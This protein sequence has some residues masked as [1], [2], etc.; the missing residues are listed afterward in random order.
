MT[1]DQFCGLALLVLC[2][3]LG[4]IHRILSPTKRAASL[5]EW[6]TAP[7]HFRVALLVVAAMVLWHGAEFLSLPTDPMTPGHVS[8]IGAM[9]TLAFVAAGLS[10]LAWALPARLK[11][12]AWDRVRWV[13]A[14]MR[15]DPD[16]R[17]I[18]V[19][20]CDV[21]D[22]AHAAGAAA[23]GPDED[24]AAA[25]REGPRYANEIARNS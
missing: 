7:E 4:M 3:I 13:V 16:L 9:T 21:T 23:V 5:K 22:I 8:A 24:P 1:L 6:P 18:M 25:Y 19:H 17:P 12:R 2:A 20:S 10:G 11:D 15:R 14:E